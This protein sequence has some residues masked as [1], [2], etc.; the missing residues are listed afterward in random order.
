M[1][2]I[3]LMRIGGIMNSGNNNFNQNPFEQEEIKN[4]ASWILTLSPFE[5]T[6]LATI[7]GYLLSLSLTTAEQ[8]SI[9]NWFELVGQII[10]TFNA[11]TEASTPPS[12]AQYCNLV[13]KVQELERI[14]YHQK[15]QD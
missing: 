15:R 11:Q 6:T 12:A 14:I 10:L 7:T 13:K 9:G 2:I 4:F 1:A 8:N 3:Y 5:F